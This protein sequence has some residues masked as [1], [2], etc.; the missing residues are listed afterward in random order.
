MKKDLPS[1]IENSDELRNQEELL[2]KIKVLIEFII[3][4]ENKKSVDLVDYLRVRLSLSEKC[5]LSVIRYFEIEGLIIVKNGVI[6]QT[7]LL[8]AFMLKLRKNINCAKNCEKIMNPFRY[9]ENKFSI[10]DKSY[11]RGEEYGGET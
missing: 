5:S 9:F 4:N 10:Q 7:E 3:I 2:T 6:E 1:K 8:S 11:G